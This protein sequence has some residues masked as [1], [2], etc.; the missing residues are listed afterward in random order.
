MKNKKAQAGTQEVIVWIIVIAVVLIAIIF[1]TKFDLNT[2]FKNLPGNDKQE[3]KD[4]VIEGIDELIKF[5]CKYPIGYIG[6][7]RN[8]YLIEDLKF[9]EGKLSPTKKSYFNYKDDKIYFRGN[10]FLIA[11]IN[12][13]KDSGSSQKNEIIRLNSEAKQFSENEFY[14]VVGITLIG[15]EIR[16]EL[17]EEMKIIDNSRLYRGVKEIGLLCAE[18]SI[19]Q[20]SI[21]EKDCSVKC[22]FFGGECSNREISSKTNIG[23]LDCENNQKCYISYN[24]KLDS[25]KPSFESISIGENNI[26]F[27]SYI[28]DEKIPLQE[29]E[30]TFSPNTILPLE[31]TADMEESTC[32]SA[33]TLDRK[34]DKVLTKDETSL[35]IL[36]SDKD[37]ILA[38]SI[39]NP[40]LEIFSYVNTNLTPLKGFG[41]YYS[42]TN[43][44]KAIVQ[45]MKV[46]EK[47]IFN[48]TGY[49]SRDKYIL[50]KL[51]SPNKPIFEIVKTTTYS[52][53]LYT[54]VERRG[55]E[56]REELKYNN[57]INSNLG[58]ISLNIF[59]KEKRAA[60]IRRLNALG[61][62][63]LGA[64]EDSLEETLSK[65][66]KDK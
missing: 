50:N 14:N 39:Y 61:T 65:I 12:S 30:I 63:S 9:K 15:E 41:T 32:L 52:I 23:K 40:K 7:D 20:E 27:Y 36:L 66:A 42:D 48:L 17:K 11:S 28:D 60:I 8:I 5:D 29:N 19:I 49:S 59:N 35:P 56:R 10:N 55:K 62:V 34:I 57:G 44:L 6:R 2:I 26:L 1:I 54:Y 18:D 13:K 25:K 38:I 4:Q 64:V 58:E 24:S 16:K 53:G 31:I 45:A 22:A 21:K 33:I 3:D 47:I 37:N 43:N 51:N 46:G